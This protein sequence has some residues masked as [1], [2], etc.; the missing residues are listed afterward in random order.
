MNAMSRSPL[1]FALSQRDAGAVILIVLG[2]AGMIHHFS[3]G[4]EAPGTPVPRSGPGPKVFV[5]TS[6]SR[7]SGSGTSPRPSDSINDMRRR[8]REFVTPLPAIKSLPAGDALAV[9][10]HSWETLPHATDPIPPAALTLSDAAAAHL[11]ASDPPSRV[12]LEIPG[13]SLHTQLQLLAAQTGLQLH[14]TGT[15]AVLDIPA[16]PPGS[17][18]Q[19]TIVSLD[20]K[21]WRQFTNRRQHFYWPD[22]ITIDL[23]IAPEVIEFEGFI[24]YGIPIQT[25]GINALGQSEPV[26]LTDSKIIQPQEGDPLY[27]LLKSMAFPPDG[28]TFTWN[29]EQGTLTT[30]GPPRIQRIAAETAAAIRESAT[31]GAS[32]EFIMVEW[33]DDQPP[34]EP[35]ANLPKARRAARAADKSSAP[36]AVTASSRTTFE[37][38]WG[39]STSGPVPA[40]VTGAEWLLPPA[41][42]SATVF[43]EASG[44]CFLL[45]LSLKFTGR[46]DVF[47]NRE[48]QP[49][50]DTL[51][52][53]RQLV[54]PGRWHP[55]KLAIQSGESAAPHQTLFVRINRTEMPLE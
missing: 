47:F 8:L 22:G 49:V 54:K 14:V 35:A 30:T 25:T 44:S 55:I 42:S 2:L 24:N 16:K 7:V 45:D 23:N 29:G 50:T 9:L 34:A 19:T 40:P 28:S 1:P 53:P 13:I 27:E 17:T 41:S 26:I 5:A 6:S 38:R 4:P 52:I 20:R 21:T 39:N 31:A 15:G 3:Q 10:Q 46:P 43:V 36:S 18:V 48:A 33:R 32:L 37:A 51:I 11:S 12:T